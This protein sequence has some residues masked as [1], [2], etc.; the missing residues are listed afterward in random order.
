MF[1]QAV[2]Q[3]MIPLV[4]TR[5]YVSAMKERLRF[6]CFHTLPESLWS[7]KKRSGSF[8]SLMTWAT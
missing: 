1:D 5:S 7:R 8:V 6:P 4:K 3:R 2:R